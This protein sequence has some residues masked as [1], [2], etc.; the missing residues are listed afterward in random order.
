[1]F[2]GF[3]P[4]VISGMLMIDVYFG[5]CQYHVSPLKSNG[6][7]IKNKDGRPKKKMGITRLGR[8]HTG[9]S[10]L[11]IYIPVMGNSIY[12]KTTD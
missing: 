6:H 9:D 1:M 7:K 2:F 3:L 12:K 4:A 10:E 5:G 8:H 11:N